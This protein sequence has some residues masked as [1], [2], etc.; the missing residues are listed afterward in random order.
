MSDGDLEGALA[1]FTGS[2]AAQPQQPEFP[3]W[4]AVLLA[5]IGRADDARAA[6]AP[7]F[8]RP[9]GD[10]WRELARRLPD[11]TIAPQAAIDALLA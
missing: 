3:F 7:V 4:Q 1:I 9:D 10:R 5:G 11:A 6:A 8:A 2:V